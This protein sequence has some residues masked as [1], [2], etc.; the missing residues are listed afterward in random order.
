MHPERLYIKAKGKN[1]ASISVKVLGVIK[2]GDN[3][4]DPSTRLAGNE[5]ELKKWFAVVRD[6]K[7]L[8]VPI[9]ITNFIGFKSAEPIRNDFQGVRE[10]RDPESK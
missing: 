1:E 9:P 3:L 2:G 7:L 4:P 8:G 5:Q 10:V 6:L